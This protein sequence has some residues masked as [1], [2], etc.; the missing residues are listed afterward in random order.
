MSVSV[1]ACSLIGVLPQLRLRELN[2]KPA[3]KRVLP[4]TRSAKPSQPEYRHASPLIF[5]A[6]LRTTS[7]GE[8]SLTQ[9]DG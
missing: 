6:S 7:S 3:V 9:S 2:A 1:F 8:N 5:P 4:A